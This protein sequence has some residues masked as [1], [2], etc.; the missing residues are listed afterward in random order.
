MWMLAGP[1]AALF[2]FSTTKVVEFPLPLLLPPLP[3]AA[4]GGGALG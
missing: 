4:A 3:D 1:Y 2:G